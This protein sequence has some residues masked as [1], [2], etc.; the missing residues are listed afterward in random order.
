MPCVIFA[1]VDTA[2]DKAA[3]IC[4]AVSRPPQR[5][6]KL[7]KVCA[8]RSPWS[9]ISAGAARTHGSV[10]AMTARG[11]AMDDDDKGRCGGGG[12]EVERD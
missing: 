2:K 8:Y 3:R 5:H 4:A 7:P 6:G 1:A 12:A 10:P 11:M 9:T